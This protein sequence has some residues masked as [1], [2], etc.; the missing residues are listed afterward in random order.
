MRKVTAQPS[1][2][3]FLQNKDFWPQRHGS[4]VRAHAALA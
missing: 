1:A 2:S 3:A 4:G